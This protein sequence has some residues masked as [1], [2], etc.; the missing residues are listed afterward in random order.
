MRITLDTT[1][2]AKTDPAAAARQQQ[3]QTEIATA[4]RAGDYQRAFALFK[5]FGNPNL[6]ALNE[7]QTLKAFGDYAAAM[8]Y[9]VSPEDISTDETLAAFEESYRNAIEN[10]EKDGKVKW[11]NV[12]VRKWY[13][14]RVT[15]I[16]DD[17]DMTLPMEERAYLAFEARNN[18]RKEARD[19]MAD[20]KTRQKLDAERPNKTF[21]ELIES[22]M[23][24]KGMTREEAIEDI[25]MTATKTNESVNKELGIEGE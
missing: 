21:E 20:E 9:D 11:D 23:K 2:A 17:I 10:A 1:K 16:P 18:I 5:E 3:Y 6:R 7:V 19:L 24:R 15:K 25:Y 12:N 4:L 13:I 8:G 22:K 14:D